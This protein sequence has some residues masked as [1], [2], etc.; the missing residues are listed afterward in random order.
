[1]EVMSKDER[2]LL[3]LLAVYLNCLLAQ[4]YLSLLGSIRFHGA[5]DWCQVFLATS[6]MITPAS[7]VCCFT[8]GSC[9]SGIST[10]FLEADT[11]TI[12]SRERCKDHYLKAQIR[13][14]HSLARSHIGQV[15][16]GFVGRRVISNE[17]GQTIADPPFDA[18]V[19]QTNF[20]NYLKFS[21]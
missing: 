12:N 5:N 11:L 18:M 7:E 9:Q 17:C 13:T 8:I 2:V 3:L 14:V 1:M 20:T 4:V 15:F 21:S 10:R 16:A 19:L 6:P